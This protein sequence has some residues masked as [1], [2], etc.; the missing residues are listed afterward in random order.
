MKRLV[1]IVLATMMFATLAVGLVSADA[2]TGSTP[3]KCKLPLLITNIGQGPDAKLSRIYFDKSAIKFDYNA[4]PGKDD[5]MANDLKGYK[6]LF[7]VIS[8]DAKGLGAS[9]ITIDDEVKRV[10]AMLKEAKKQGITIVA[11]N[12]TGSA[13]RGNYNEKSIDA[14][15]SY[16]DAFV[17][18]TDGDKD[19]RFTN[20]ATKYK[21]PIT[22]F[23]NTLQDFGSIISS[24]FK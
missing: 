21:K 4:E 22:Y 23:S 20:I 10:D 2:I 17:I 8:S 15:A 1:A 19:K 14:I 6:T 9:G 11:C 7:C 16:A 12:T 18:N 13:A 24:M 3:L 5:P